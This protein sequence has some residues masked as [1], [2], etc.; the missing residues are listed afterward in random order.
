MASAHGDLQSLLQNPN[1]NTLLG[2][3]TSVTIGDKAAD[4]NGGNKVCKTIIRPRHC[5][6]FFILMGDNPSDFPARVA[7]V[8]K[9]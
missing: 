2:G 9:A 3:T 1:L 4:E 6:L 8:G 7:C 5:V